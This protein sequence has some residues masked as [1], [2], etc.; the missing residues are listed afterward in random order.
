MPRLRVTFPVRTAL[1][2]TPLL[3]S[4][5]GDPD[6]SGSTTTSSQGGGGSSTTTT[7]TSSAGGGGSGA[8]GTG[9]VTGGTGGATGG[10]G[11]TGGATTGGSAGAGGTTNPLCGNGAIDPGEDCDG[12]D[13][14]DATCVSIGYPGGSL[15]CNATCHFDTGAC[16]DSDFCADG[17][18]NN[19][20]G[21]VDCEEL[22]CAE[23]CASACFA[24]V[25]MADGEGPSGYTVGHANVLH[26]S[27]VAES[28]PEL[29]Y[30]VTATQTGA[31]DVSLLEESGAP[32]SISV[33][34][35][36]A[37]DDS[38]IAC[39]D[40]YLP[41][42]GDQKYL[43]VPITAGQTVFVVVDGDGASAAGSFTVLAQTRA[44]FCGDGQEDPPDTC[45]D[46]NTTSGDGCDAT[47]QVES[48]ETE[49]NGSLATANP[50]AAPWFAQIS[51]A[52]DVDVVQLSLPAAGGLA[53]WTEGLGDSACLDG[54]LDTIVTLLDA[55]GNT[56]ASNDD[57]AAACS[58]V[59]VAS[60]PPGVYYARI[61]APAGAS[62]AAATFPYRLQTSTFHCGDGAL[63]VGEECD[64]GNAAN[65]DGCSSS[66][67]VEVNETEPNGTLLLADVYTSPW[68]AR[69]DPD[70]DVDVVL[71]T[72]PAGGSKI[73]ATTLDPKGGAGCA[74]AIETY[75]EILGA[76]GA[77]LAANNDANGGVCSS[78]SA[79]GL[80]AG[81]YYV[82]VQ[83]P[84]LL[85][86]DN[87]FIYSYKL[88]IKVQ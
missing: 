30:A 22:D 78:A 12:A 5:C 75:V 40:A 88:D 24:P 16:S 48:T 79:Q 2:L 3:L 67:K 52:G 69:V 51:P 11:G 53:V 86:A 10:T 44:L 47:C 35:D 70:G 72:V 37:S 9:G 73:T 21:K 85:G 57:H 43:S 77:V 8:G 49:P 42:T 87:V 68:V 28:G 14:G 83:A 29:V 13:L 15:G 46:G 4:A 23:E 27:C 74:S 65:G 31:L 1:L 26:A 55:A 7:T 59:S 64:D 54:S 34:T 18:D 61:E 25:A 81:T 58:L 6:T 80:A 39:S 71:V 84:P 66:C 33:R 50:L 36:C 20:N 41:G 76:G 82:R 38:E 62:Q 19:A 32:L 63:A 45:D 60:L 17:I 56:L